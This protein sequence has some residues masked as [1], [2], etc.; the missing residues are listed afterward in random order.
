MV[1]SQRGLQL[2]NGG[3]YCIMERNGIQWKYKGEY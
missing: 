1:K 2:C 3:I